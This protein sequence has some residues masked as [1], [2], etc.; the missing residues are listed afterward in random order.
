[1]RK[2]TQQDIDDYLQGLQMEAYDDAKGIPAE[3]RTTKLS[4]LN[5]LTV[6]EGKAF[7]E[8][9][10]EHLEIPIYD[11]SESFTEKYLT[12]AF[13]QYFDITGMEHQIAS[14]GIK[15]DMQLMQVQEARTAFF[16]RD[17]KEY[18]RIVDSLKPVVIPNQP[19]IHTSVSTQAIPQSQEG[20]VLTLAEAWADFVKYKSDWTSRYK[21]EMEG[22]FSF[23]GLILGVDT[24]VTQIKKSDIKNMLEVVENLPQRNKNPYKKMTP[25]ECIDCDDIGEDEFI[26]SKSVAGYL[27][28][29]QSLFSSY[30]TDYKDIYTVSPTHGVKYDS[31]SKPYGVYSQTEMK[32]LVAYFISLSDWK[33]W[34][35]LL[36]A[37]T[38]ARRKEIAT[39]TAESVRLDADSGRYYLMIE[40]SKTEAGTRQIPL[41]NKLVEL[42]FINL[43]NQIGK[44]K[45]FPQVTYNNQITKA[46]HDIREH[47][48]IPY[49]NDYSE[50][51]IVH[52]LRHTFIT[53]ALKNTGNHIL[54][55]Q[56]VGH[57]HSNMGQTKRY[58]HKL[59]VSDL[60]CVV[61]GIKWV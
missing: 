20:N 9:I 17:L 40:D 16:S 46:F 14:A 5:P 8:F 6:D 4:G 56:V 33:K 49:L 47:L 23:I 43:V 12:G 52:S 19:T 36:L 58:T 1:M 29:C 2:L 60:L 21:K 26:A 44:G 11:G 30:L 59:P 54:V 38:G 55:Q 3:A 25:Q 22:M 42:G 24:P 39:L 31:K 18:Q 32:N 51:R 61:D 45:L 48:D 10:G 37:Y 27:K 35:F 7:A 57:E 13:S 15:H 50:R 28:L 41:H 34:V 53:S